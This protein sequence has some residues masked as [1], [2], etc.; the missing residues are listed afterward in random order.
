MTE[1]LVNHHK[2]NTFI[3]GIREIY[4]WRKKAGYIF[5]DPFEESEQSSTREILYGA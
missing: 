3:Y 4:Q 5:V 1:L 2:K